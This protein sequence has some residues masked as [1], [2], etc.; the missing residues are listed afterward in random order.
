MSR[1]NEPQNPKVINSAGEFTAVGYLTGGT[2]MPVNMVAGGSNPSDGTVGISHGT[3]NIVYQLG[4]LYYLAGLGGG[5]VNVAL[6]TFIYKPPATLVCGTKLVAGT[7]TPETLAASTPLWNSV[8]IQ[9]LYSNV[10]TVFLKCGTATPL[11]GVS[12]VAR[13]VATIVIDDLAKVYVAVT[14]AGEG[15]NYVGS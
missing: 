13:D 1:R 5:T 3:L 9:A 7:A 15:V 11:S 10:G 14:T 2:P 4:T 12:M 6:G 8:M